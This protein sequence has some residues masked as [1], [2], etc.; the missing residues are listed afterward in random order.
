MTAIATP[1][2]H[3]NRRRH[4]LAVPSTAARIDSRFESRWSSLTIRLAVAADAAR[5]RHLAH[6]DSARPL[7]GQALL[8]EQSG[9]VIAALSLSDGAVIADPFV[10]SADAVAMLR[11]RAGQLRESATAA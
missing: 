4:L 3:T 5:L 6:M 1:Q 8:A 9:A 2:R 10:P 11:L 7:S